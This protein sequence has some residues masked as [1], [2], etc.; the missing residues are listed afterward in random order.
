M[1]A[2]VTVM[3]LDPLTPFQVAVMVDVPGDSVCVRPLLP[4]ASL[5]CA[6]FGL[7]D[8]HVAA[9]V[10]CC[11]VLSLRMAVAAN[12]TGTPLATLGSAGAISIEVTDA[13]VTVI[14]AVPVSPP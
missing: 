4:A 5:T 11:E 14:V 13:P 12:F 3:I 6:T 7:E 8:V 9:P 1:V 10:T 2:A